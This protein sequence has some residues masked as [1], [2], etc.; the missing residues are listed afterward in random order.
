MAS[1]AIERLPECDRPV[2]AHTATRGVFGSG[3]AL[4]RR[5]NLSAVYPDAPPADSRSTA[6]VEP[7]V[8]T[9]NQNTPERYFAVND[10]CN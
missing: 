6:L 10:A 2:N 1:A 9:W 3:E 7:A 8:P 5:S 4:V